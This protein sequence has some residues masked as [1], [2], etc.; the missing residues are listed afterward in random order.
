MRTHLLGALL[1]SLLARDAGAQ[2]SSRQPVAA[3]MV[4]V[5]RGTSACLVRPSACTDEVVVYRITQM[6]T[7]DSLA[8]DARK[9]VGREE[10]EMGVLGCRLVPSSA[11]I[12]CAVPQ[13][14]LA[15]HHA[16]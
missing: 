2:S 5:W 3:T 4:G 7:S 9:I 15:L 1:G 6:K 8:V 13:G 11:Q 14:M 16:Q 10:Q 12:F